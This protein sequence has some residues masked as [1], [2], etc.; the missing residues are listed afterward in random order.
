[1]TI[2]RQGLRK[3]R[4]SRDEAR[5]ALWTGIGCLILAF[6]I[7]FG[8]GLMVLDAMPGTGAL[9]EKGVSNEIR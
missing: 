1:M 8:F 4:P 3:S 6:A 5:R 2:E 7:V 9:N